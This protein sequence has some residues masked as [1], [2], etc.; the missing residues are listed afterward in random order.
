LACL[1]AAHALRPV[2]AQST[3]VTLRGLVTS[4]D[5]AVVLATGGPSTAASPFDDASA[6]PAILSTPAP[7]PLRASTRLPFGLGD[8]VQL[9]LDSDPLRGRGSRASLQLREDRWWISDDT[10]LTWSPALAVARAAD[11]HRFAS[12]LVAL[13]VDR[14]W[15]PDL[16]GFAQLRG[17]RISLDGSAV[18]DLS[19]AVGLHRAMRAGLQVDVSLAHGL[20]PNA[21]AFEARGGVGL[22]F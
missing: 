5:P 16:R 21:P 9:R 4:R 13:T 1:L 22:K 7:A 3:M 19:F 8:L 18:P 15:S 14:A 2:A 12:G 6:A 17:E 11:G 20:T 10:V